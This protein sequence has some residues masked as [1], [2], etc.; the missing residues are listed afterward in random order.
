MNTIIKFLKFISHLIFPIRCM[1][2]GEIIEYKEILCKKCYEEVRNKIFSKII[3]RPNDEEVIECISPFKYEGEVRNAILDFKFNGHKEYADF[4]AKEI[5]NRLKVHCKIAD[6]DY[7]CYVPDS[8]SK[9]KKKEFNQSRC[10]SLAIGKILNLP[11]VDIISKNKETKKQHTLD[12]SERA[13]NLIGAFSKHSEN[14]LV[15]KNVLLCDD[16]VTT[17]NTLK[18]C[19]KVLKESKVNKVLCCTIAT[20][21]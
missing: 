2:C 3:Y 8:K 12:A 10:L 11:V 9:M 7:I 1:F 15:G 13:K 5:C 16:I 17:G 19:V 6:I 4:F 21:G 18:E 14:I 20:A